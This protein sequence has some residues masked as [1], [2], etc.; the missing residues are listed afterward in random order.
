[1]FKLFA[2]PFFLSLL[3]FS[4]SPLPAQS[5]E[6]S[7]GA[8]Y[9]VANHPHFPSL[10]QP[11][12]GGALAFYTPYRWVQKSGGDWRDYWTR[13]R[14]SWRVYAQQLGNARILGNAWAFVPTMSMP[15]QKGGRFWLSIGW[16]LGR[17]GRRFEAVGNA[18]NI[19]MGAY[20]NAAVT[21]SLQ[22]R[23][24]RGWGLNFG[25]LHLSN[26]GTATPNLGANIAHIGLS[27]H[28]GKISTADTTAKAERRLLR[29]KPLIRQG[30]AMAQLALGWAARGRGGLLFPVYTATAGYTRALSRAYAL[31]ARL[32]YSYNT[33]A[34]EWH[35]YNAAPQSEPLPFGR[36]ALSLEQEWYLGRWSFVAGGGVYLHAHAE[37]RARFTTRVGAN[38]YPRSNLLHARHQC[39]LGLHVR[40]NFGEAECIETLIGYRF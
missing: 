11:V 22:W 17:V 37:Q 25:I 36:W 32:E 30:Q 23:F 1:M 27:Y 7:A 18:E 21:A 34:A 10:R 3:L 8:G 14:F 9:S 38:F 5:W 16:G 13:A 28:F 40:A 29:R 31:T 15:L 35:R 4:S 20:W 33:A 24:W 2:F 19:V 12:L 6:L 26:G 39:W